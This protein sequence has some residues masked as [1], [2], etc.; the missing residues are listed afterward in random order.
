MDIVGYH[1]DEL[2]SIY[3]HGAQG[4]ETIKQ[5]MN[6]L[7]NH[8]LEEL[9]GIKVSSYDDYKFLVNKDLEGNI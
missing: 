1:S 8:T 2:Y 5:I 7:R 4:K 9:C 3:F 6:K